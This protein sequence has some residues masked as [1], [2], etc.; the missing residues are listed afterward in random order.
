MSEQYKNKLHK[1]KVI[2]VAVEELEHLGRAR[3]CGTDITDW[4]IVAYCLAIV[5]VYL[6]I[7][8]ILFNS[9]ICSFVVFFEYSV[10]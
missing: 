10:S 3:A 4:K 9:L 8:P 2:W 5:D 1:Y 7:V 6:R